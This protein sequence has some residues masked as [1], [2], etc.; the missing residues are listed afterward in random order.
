MKTKF[1]YYQKRSD[2]MMCTEEQKQFSC[3]YG[4]W[5][6][7]ENKSLGGAAQPFGA[8]K[9]TSLA[10]AQKFACDKGAGSI[11]VSYRNSIWYIYYIIYKKFLKTR[12][13][14]GEFNTGQISNLDFPKISRHFV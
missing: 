1:G 3:L 14:S 10:E 11:I 2:D 7:L 9:F 12:E 8:K 4:V 13:I 6:K 5:K